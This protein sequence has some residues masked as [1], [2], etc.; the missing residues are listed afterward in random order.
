MDKLP[1]ADTVI[2]IIHDN[3]RYFSFFLA[4]PVDLEIT[5]MTM[6]MMMLTPRPVRH[7]VP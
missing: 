2:I 7:A 3:Y 5:D 1:N 6:M 4:F